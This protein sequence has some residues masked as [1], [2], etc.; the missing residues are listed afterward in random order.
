M[1]TFTADPA[2]WLMQYKGS[3][4]FILAGFV[5]V[6]VVYAWLKNASPTEIIMRMMHARRNRL[7]AMLE[8]SFLSKEAKALAEQELRQRSLYQLTG[9]YNYRVQGLA[10]G[11]ITRFGLHTRYLTPWRSWLS[12]SDG[13]ITFNRKSYRFAW[14][15]FICGTFPLSLLIIA[16]ITFSVAH[17][18][19]YPSAALALVL[20]VVLIFYWLIF[21]FVPGPSETRKM[22]ARLKEFNEQSA[23]RERAP[24][25]YRARLVPPGQGREAFPAPRQKLFR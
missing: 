22:E 24:S 12:E 4:W 10:V 16:L 6:Q 5:A 13:L 1:Q 25:G 8:E 9:L 15:F 21:A 7:L 14:W 3:G 17:Q 2:N 23:D 11:L 20:S 19:G 18:F